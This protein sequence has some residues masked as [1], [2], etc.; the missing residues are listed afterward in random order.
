MD[1]ILVIPADLYN[2]IHLE[3]ENYDRTGEFISTCGSN[4][5]N[6]DTKKEGFCRDSVF[7]IT[8][9]HNSGARPCEC[10]FQGSLSF[11]CEKF[12]GQC[13]CRP[14]IIGRQCKA[15]KTGYYGFPDCKPCNCPSTA[16]CEPATGECICPKHVTGERC[17]QCEPLTYGY[18]PIIGCEVCNCNSLG[19]I[20]NNHQ[21]DLLNGSCP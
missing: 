16:Y 19:V 14:N 2:D 10:D 7:S 3:E 21:C 20:Y 15:C 13:E 17:D 1:Y 12:G 11:E 9:A 6:I 4:H 8:A 5:F 18:D